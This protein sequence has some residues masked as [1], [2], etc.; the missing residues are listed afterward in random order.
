MKILYFLFSPL[1]RQKRD[2]E[3]TKESA[4]KNDKNFNVL[5]VT[6]SIEMANK[7][8]LLLLFR[9]STRTRRRRRAILINF[10]DFDEASGE[11]DETCDMEREN[12][13]VSLC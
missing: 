1:R 7:K 6:S 10:D 13:C 11:R 3:Q 5:A 12:R 9:V 2:D 8:M 4:R